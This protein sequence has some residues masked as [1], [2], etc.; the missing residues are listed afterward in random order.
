MLI[1]LLHGVLETEKCG[2]QTTFFIGKVT[3]ILMSTFLLSY[4][5]N[6]LKSNIA[7]DFFVFSTFHTIFAKKLI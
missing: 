4:F 2:Q 6:T 1:K 3:S 7:E 5:L